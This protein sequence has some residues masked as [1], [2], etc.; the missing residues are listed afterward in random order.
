MSFIEEMIHDFLSYEFKKNQLDQIVVKL[1]ENE[2]EEF[3]FDDDVE[4]DW[5][6]KSITLHLKRSYPKEKFKPLFDLGIEKV[7][8]R[9]HLFE[10]I[11]L[12]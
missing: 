7:L 3:D 8:I 6:N 10:T 9:K 2:Q 4:F 5:Y 11:T 12:S 1:F